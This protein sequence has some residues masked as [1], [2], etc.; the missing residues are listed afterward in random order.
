MNNTIAGYIKTEHFMLRQWE[1]KIEDKLINSALSKLSGK[2]QRFLLVISR[3]IVK[4]LSGKNEELFILIKGRILV[5]CFY[6]R[7][8]GH[9][10]KRSRL[11]YELMQ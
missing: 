4:E 6:G 7:L 8:E 3:N 1:R 9:F 2:K 11:S 5:T 10:N